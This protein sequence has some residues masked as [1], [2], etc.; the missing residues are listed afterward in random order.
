MILISELYKDDVIVGY[1]KHENGRIYH[2][3][4]EHDPDMKPYPFYDILTIDFNGNHFYYIE[5]DDKN[6]IGEQL[7]ELLIQQKTQKH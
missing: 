1:E 5:H 4:I 7:Y 3:S 2:Q 6:I